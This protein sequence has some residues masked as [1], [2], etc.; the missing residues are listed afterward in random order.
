M[1]KALERIAAATENEQDR[2]KPVVDAPRSWT[3]AVKPVLDSLI[4]QAS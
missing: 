2:L 4:K 3:K 1:A